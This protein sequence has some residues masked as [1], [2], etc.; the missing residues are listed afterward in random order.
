VREE[1]EWDMRQ[2]ERHIGIQTV[3]KRCLL[4]KPEGATDTRAT[5][6][7]YMRCCY[8]FRNGLVQK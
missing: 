7:D 4:G 3:R 2:P 1:E 5:D 8:L 6:T